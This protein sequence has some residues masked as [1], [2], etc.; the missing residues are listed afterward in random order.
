MAKSKETIEKKE[1]GKSDFTNSKKIRL[2]I[3]ERLTAL[4]ESKNLSQKDMA[5]KCDLSA[6]T[7][8]KAITAKE[9]LSIRN[10]IKISKAF[11]VSLDYIYGSSNIINIQQYALD[12]INKQ[13]EFETTKPTRERTDIFT[14]ISFSKKLDDYLRAIDEINKND[15]MSDKLKAMYRQEV[16]DKFI[17]SLKEDS[18]VEDNT[19]VKNDT[20]TKKKSNRDMV[21]YEVQC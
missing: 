4:K 12:L 19:E 9:T 16:T 6:D 8:S 18:E 3:S 7:I 21:H 14:T 10:A 20:N 15:I 2:I 11:G 5:E 17:N 1:N 13:I